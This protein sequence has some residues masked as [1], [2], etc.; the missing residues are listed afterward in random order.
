M[1]NLYVGQERKTQVLENLLDEWMSRGSSYAT[2][3]E[4]K[5]NT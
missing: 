2:S 5:T 3:D 1:T 4:Y